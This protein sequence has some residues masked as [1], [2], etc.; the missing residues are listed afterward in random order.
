MFLLDTDVLSASRRPEKAGQGLASWVAT[1]NPRS[2]FLSAVSI[3]EVKIGAL[4][5]SRR[6]QA[7]SAELEAW[8]HDRVLT[9]FHGRIIPFD[10]LTALRCAPFHVPST[11][12]ERDAMIAATALQHRLTVVT[13]NVRHF[14]RMGVPFLNPWES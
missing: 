14:G 12:P 10:A 13:R 11:P 9:K 6:D 3:L 8:I 1:T 5:L 2:M 4:R 7:R